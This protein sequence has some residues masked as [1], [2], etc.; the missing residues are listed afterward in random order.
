MICKTKYKKLK[1]LIKDY[2]DL[3]FRV[4]Y[5]LKSGGWDR[6]C[7]DRFAKSRKILDIKLEKLGLE[8]QCTDYGNEYCL[9]LRGLKAVLTALERINEKGKKLCI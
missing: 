1:T 7:R 4:S 8:F 3:E 5:T 9:D 6:E 2:D